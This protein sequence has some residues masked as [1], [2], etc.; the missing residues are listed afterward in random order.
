MS[1]SPSPALKARVAELRALLDRANRAYYV[2]ANPI[3]SDAEFDRLLAEL[4][5]IEK[6]H[7][8][9]DD[10]DSPT[11]RVGG[12][13]I[14]GFAQVRH[15][16]PM[17]SIDNTYNEAEVREWYQRMLRMLGAGAKPAGSLF[18]SAGPA[19]SNGPD[20][21]LRVVADPKIDGVAVSLRYERG[22]LAVAATRGD[23]A[24]GD[25]I[26]ASVRAIRPIP[27]RLDA[28]AGIP[29]P[30]VLEVRGEIFMPLREFARINR[31]REA[32]G[33]E[34]FMNPRNAT[35]GTLKQLDPK[36]V[37]SRRLSFCAYGRGEIRAGREPFAT[38][39]AEFLKKVKALGL[40]VSPHSCVCDSVEEVLRCIEEFGAKR[41][42]LDY[43]TD[44][45]VVRVDS[46]EL[47]ERL[48]VTSKSPRWVIAYKYPAERK[49]TK[50][51]DVYHQV[52]KT[53]RIT[54][55][56]VMEPVLLAGTTVQHA[57]LHNYGRVRDAAIEGGEGR[58]DIRIGDTVVVEKAGEI[59]PQV[60]AVVL[61][62]RP[63]DA[64][65]IV[66]PA[67]CPECGGPV[68]LEPPEAE[69]HPALET[70][71]RCVNP[72]CPAQVRERLIWFAGRKQM[73]I[74]GLGEKT[75][76]QIRAE[77]KIPLNSFAD[78][79]RLKDHRDELLALDRMGEKKVDNLL[80]GIEAAKKRGLARVLAGMGIRHVGNATAKQLARVFRD[81]DAL[82]AAD[83][84]LLRPKTL[85][86]DE[87]ARYGLP[88]DPAERIE[89][90]LGHD[91]APVVHAYLHSEVARH[92]FDE[93]R[94]VG[95]DLTSHDYIEPK[96]RAAAAGPFAGKTVVIT[97][98]LD[99]YEREELKEKLESLGA[100]VTGSVSSKTS[101]LI[102]GRD[103]GSKLD[104][105][106][107]LGVEIW[108]EERLLKEL[109]S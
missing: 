24:V 39:H 18:E 96:A 17:L 97:G 10:P 2:E 102:V 49:T 89:T 4:A 7:P 57:T 93:L 87:A 77:S 75:V 99:S 55:R 54:P 45:M 68:E 16:V 8:E 27:V 101:L 52:G 72:E 40:P 84:P 28:D 56:A 3:M 38:G 9:L 50:L 37:A 109:K 21:G 62:K 26:T 104:K 95:V 1:P 47:Q 22:R 6:E 36:I 70:G 13:P 30:E 23:G 20:R 29:I 74:E 63:R 51:L 46:F 66:P 83:E 58:T 43:Q 100:K 5:A 67:R 61:D 15:A 53:G 14:E 81:I 60:V 59:I 65:P 35:A 91:T 64:K 48:G 69:Q 106:R 105:A 76:D 71:R 103:P 73:D 19:E 92:T 41:A 33:D 32:E 82:L 98:T 79:F 86:R 94:A 12:E 80:A 42:T 78:I 34:P 88:E 108:D 25:D 85:K 31:E 44:G 107:E 11:H 90:G